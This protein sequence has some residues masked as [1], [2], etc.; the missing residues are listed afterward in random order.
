MRKKETINQLQKEITAT[1]LTVRHLRQQ[2]MQQLQTIMTLK[3]AMHA[4]LT[5]QEQEVFDALPADI[6]TM[7]NRSADVI[8]GAMRTNFSP[9]TVSMAVYADNPDHAA[10]KVVNALKHEKKTVTYTVQPVPNKPTRIR[11]SNEKPN[12]NQRWTKKEDAQLR[13]L[14]NQN[15]EWSAIAD[16]LGRTAK[17][18]KLRYNKVK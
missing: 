8:D 2:V 17:A 12:G 4:P 11:T 10:T 16:Q 9:R 3:K 6:Q 14:V 15:K 18:C 1:D 7:I 5:P 13:R